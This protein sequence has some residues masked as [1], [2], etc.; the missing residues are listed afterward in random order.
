MHREM[1]LGLFV[2]TPA[3]TSRAA[4]SD[5]T[6]TGWPNLPLM[7]HI[8]KT[9]EAAKFDMFFLG[10][11]FATG[12]PRASLDHRQVRTADVCRRSP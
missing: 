11:G 5:A 10:D 3:T 2:Q 12:G 4:A 7:Q 8:A 1:R 9:A 6:A